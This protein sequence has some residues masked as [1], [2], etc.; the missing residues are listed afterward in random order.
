MGS[1][2]VG[3]DCSNLAAA[4]GVKKIWRK[5]KWMWLLK[6]NMRDPYDGNVLYLD[7]INT[8]IL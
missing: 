1:H 7:C 8:I 5:E 6:R 3:H 2:R 4:A